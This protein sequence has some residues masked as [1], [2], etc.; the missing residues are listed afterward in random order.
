MRARD[1]VSCAASVTTRWR[2]GAAPSDRL[3]LLPLES[4]RARRRRPSARRYPH[5]LVARLSYPRAGEPRPAALPP[6]ERTV[7]QLVAESIRIYGE[8]FVRC[9]AIGVPP[10]AL[11]ARDART[12]RAGSRSSWRRRSTARCSARRT[13]TPATLVLEQRPPS[14]RLVAA[15]LAGWLVFVPAPFLCSGSCCRRS[16]GFA[17]FGLVVPV[18]VVEELGVR[19]AF[20]R[21]WQLGPGR[22]RARARL[23]RDARDRR[24]SS[25]RAVLALHPPRAPRPGARDAVRARERRHLAA[26]SSSARR[27]STWIRPP[28]SS[29]F[30]AWRSTSFSR[31]CRSRAWRR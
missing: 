18:L 19:A 26:R 17:A 10:A 25:R 14:A 22:L 8:R 2:R 6:G 16:P 13:S 1:S 5:A 4:A 27:S 3:A 29:R 7:G 20:A 21:A 15:W 24:R 31:G 30:P 12:S 28:G 23:A 11:D 9:L